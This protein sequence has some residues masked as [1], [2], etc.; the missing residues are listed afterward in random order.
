M[1]LVDVAFDCGDF[2]RVRKGDQQEDIP[3]SNIANVKHGYVTKGSRVIAL[4]LVKPG[5]LGS[6]IYF[7]HLQEGWFFSKSPIVDELKDRAREARSSR[8]QKSTKI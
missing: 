4:V 8:G 6:V 3:L 7:C 1:R 2:L 5:K